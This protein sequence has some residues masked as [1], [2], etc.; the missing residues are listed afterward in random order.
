[1]GRGFCGHEHLQGT[2]GEGEVSS[3]RGWE[4]NDL[5]VS[6]SLVLILA[7]AQHWTSWRYQI[8]L[9]SLPLPSAG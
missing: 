9:L 5:D 4:K 6:G 7:T 8:A 1:M 3:W 2:G